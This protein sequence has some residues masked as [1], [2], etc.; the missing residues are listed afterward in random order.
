MAVHCNNSNSSSQYP[1]VC[2]V[3]NS[4]SQPLL[5]HHTGHHASGSSQ[6]QHQAPSPPAYYV[7]MSGDN[8]GGHCTSSHAPLQQ[9][10]HCQQ[11]YHNH[12]NSDNQSDCS[13]SPRQRDTRC[14]GILVGLFI[15]FF[16]M[17]A[18]SINP[19]PFRRSGPW[20]AASGSTTANPN[21]L[22][23]LS[24][25][26]NNL[27]FDRCRDNAIDWDGP[28]TFTTE[29][30]NFRLKIGQGNIF[31]RVNIS[32]GPVA[33]PTLHILGEVTPYEDDV[34]NNKPA[35]SHGEKIDIDYLGLHVE[36]VELDNQFDAQVWYHNREVVDPRD[37]QHYRACAR[38][39]FEVIL[40]E[41]FTSYGSITIDGPVVVINAQDLENVKFDRL[42]FG[43]TVGE[44]STRGRIQSDIFDAKSN[45]GRVRADAIQV[46][47]AGK[48]LDI[49]VSSVTGSI[50]LTAETT[51]VDASQ[52]NPHKVH[53]STN[54]GRTQLTVQPSTSS[55]STIGTKHGNLDIST[56]AVTG[57]IDTTTILASQ[58][59]I[60]TLT[61]KTNTGSIR[62]HI[63]DA[64]LGHFA[65]STKW[66]STRVEPAKDSKSTITYDK[67][68]AR[69]KIG[70]KSLEGT[71]G[72]AGLIEIRTVTGSTALEFTN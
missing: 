42:H 34:K 33:V 62:N 26:S 38:L 53:V 59:Q 17:F 63:S 23:L 22:D 4:E 66:G 61:S 31:S 72:V 21:G 51:D 10:C 48:P 64:F 54:T 9:Q 7:D 1:S 71:E 60:L 52:E 55:S 20:N 19:G 43:S 28:S 67:L 8:K 6:H 14:T 41:S 58:D 12:H 70:T 2:C 50:Q 15:V 24:N 3:Y 57:S 32:T 35:A 46:A 37:G 65:L 40:P 68:N 47:T 30:K 36:I 27:N 44:I 69:E 25:D 13:R 39:Y 29:V 45:T 56:T 11:H 16:I 49:Q 18:S 5:G